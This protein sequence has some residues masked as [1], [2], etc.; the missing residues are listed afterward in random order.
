LALTG[1]VVVL[2]AHLV[3]VLVLDRSVSDLD[4]EQEGN[5]LAWLSSTAAGAAASAALLLALVAPARRV[6]G[7]VLAGGLAFLS[8]S[9]AAQVHERLGFQVAERL[10]GGAQEW[11]NQ[12]Q[13]LVVLPPL[14]AVFLGVVVLAWESPRGLRLSLLGG[15]SAL[16]GAL[17]IEQVVGP[18][19]NALEENGILWPDAVRN[20]FEE[21]VEV[22]GWVLL[23]TGLFALAA[24]ALTDRPAGSGTLDQA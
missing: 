23:T 3:G 18:A 21:G 24:W 19:T 17:V 20:G 5:A 8:L 11:E 1:F 22:A 12:V 14:A 10:L 6:L 13:V 15:L 7:L 16:L 9:E 2:T 4:A